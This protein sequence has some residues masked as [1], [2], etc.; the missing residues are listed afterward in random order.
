MFNSNLKRDFS[1]KKSAY[2]TGGIL[3]VVTTL[4][5][6][7]LFSAVILFFN[8]DR[9]Y[10]APFATI[11]VA[12]GCFTA[13]RKTAKMIGDRGYLTGTIIGVSVFLVIT[14]ISLIFGNGITI[15][16]LFHFVIIIL[17]S[18]AGGIIGVNAKQKKY[19]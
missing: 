2:I 16:T 8:L 3:G 15:N 17:S 7:L 14:I 19:I 5:M 10:S 13:S 4:G 18:L 6:M 9:T 11:S 12:F 1:G